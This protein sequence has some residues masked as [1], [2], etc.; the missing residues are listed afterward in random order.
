MGLEQEK[1]N[2]EEITKTQEKKYAEIREQAEN[3]KL[4]LTKSSIAE[5]AE[6]AKTYMADVKNKYENP[7]EDYQAEVDADDFAGDVKEAATKGEKEGEAII[8]KKKNHVKAMSLKMKKAAMK[9]RG[10]KNLRRRLL[11]RQSERGQRLF[12]KKKKKKKKK[13]RGQ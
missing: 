4:T 9:L 8:S 11:N 13:R 3:G 2:N 6:T 12:K 1:K 7:L 10:K 5:A